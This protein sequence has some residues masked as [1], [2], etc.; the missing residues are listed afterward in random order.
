MEHCITALQTDSQ[1]CDFGIKIARARA[2]R[3]ELSATQ[4]SKSRKQ[5]LTNPPTNRPFP[6]PNRLLHHALVCRRHHLPNRTLP[7]P[8]ERPRQHTPTLGRPERSPPRC[9]AARERRRRHVG[10]ER[11][12][13]PCDVRGRARGQGRCCAILAGSGRKGR[14]EG[15]K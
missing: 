1:V 15:W 4:T 7:Q 3:R 12:R 8:P 5:P 2:R 11:S 9:Q 6:H 14:R 13:T 10:Q